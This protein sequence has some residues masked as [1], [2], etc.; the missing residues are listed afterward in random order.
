MTFNQLTE[1]ITQKMSMSHIYQPLLIQKLVEAGGTATI[2]Q[3][4]TE[5]LI[6]DESLIIDYEKTLKNMP[7][8]V[9]SKHNVVKREGDLIKLVV[10][11]LSLQQKA[12]ILKQCQRRM[13]NYIQKRGLSIWDYRLKDSYV[14]DS[15]R[16]K[17]L[18]ESDGRC[19]LCGAT[20]KERPLDVDHI[21]P[22]SKGGKTTIDN[23][24]VLCSKCNRS[25]RNKD[26]TDFR[27][28][29]DVRSDPSCGF[30]NINKSV[31]VLETRLSTVVLDK[32]P[33]TEGHTLFIPKRHFQDFFQITK[34]EHSVLF[35][36]IKVRRNYLTRTDKSI[37]GFNIGVNSGFA[38][39]QTINHVHL[40]LIPR[41]NN[42]VDD[43]R[44]GIRGVIPS[45]MHY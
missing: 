8:K 31:L 6:H 37:C 28:F 14:S 33:V 43:P 27:F 23:L 25:K 15:L 10:N 1:F 32:Y 26:N 3:L 19:T 9:L 5:F 4:A 39:G 45:M 2:R 29:N 13:L 22:L 30:C 35:D 38:A 40:H 11:P 7:I 17:V 36:L 20:K 16:Y 42:D 12:E 41:R 34:K 44:G 21:I 18:K 24:Q